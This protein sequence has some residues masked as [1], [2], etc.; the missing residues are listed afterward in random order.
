MSV[1]MEI[2]YDNSVRAAL[3]NL[4]GSSRA[5]TNGVIT[6]LEKFGHQLRMPYSKKMG[7]NLFEL[8]VSGKEAIRVFYTIRNNRVILLHL[9]KK[10]SQ[11]TPK[12]E[13][14]TAT[15]KLKNLKSYNVNDIM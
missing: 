5:K 2:L 3:L 8:R 7:P 15:R 13:V 10:K 9:F 1:T 11:K 12:R 14:K 6:L 4:E